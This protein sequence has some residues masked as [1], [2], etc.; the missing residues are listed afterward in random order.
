[1]IT[2]VS[3]IAGLCFHVTVVFW[4]VSHNFFVVWFAVLAW[5]SP[6]DQFAGSWNV[7]ILAMCWTGFAAFFPYQSWVLLLELKNVLLL[8]FNF[9][10]GF[11][12]IFGFLSSQV[13][14][15]LGLPCWNWIGH[16][17][18]VLVVWF[19][20]LWRLFVWLIVGFRVFLKVCV[21]LGE[22]GT[23]WCF[24]GWFSILDFWGKGWCIVRSGVVVLKLL[25]G[26]LKFGFK[27]LF[28][29]H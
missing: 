26:S 21:W 8:F 18:F 1:M 7:V 3:L 20:A 11:H 27:K 25:F 29:Q 9:L 15:R 17:N 24:F 23:V 2:Q 5:V 10:Q 14:R 16:V 28:L 13:F 4:K 19:V 22:F 12:V 6:A